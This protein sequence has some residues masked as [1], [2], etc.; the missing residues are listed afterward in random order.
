M[1]DEEVDSELLDLLN[2]TEVPAL[3]P[4]TP[5]PTITEPTPVAAP[6]SPSLAQALIVEPET[7]PHQAIPI[8]A[9]N[10][11]KPEDSLD[12]LGIKNLLEGFHSTSK[13]IIDNHAADRAQVDE[14]LKYLETQVKASV[15]AGDKAQTAMVDGWVK[16]L[17]TKAEINTNAVS[18]LDAQ[19]K[20][21]AAVKNNNVIVNV[22]GGSVGEGEIDL[23]TVF[24]QPLN[25]DEQIKSVL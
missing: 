3:P 21:L 4:T 17:Q 6:S 15:S 23:K 16:L 12:K 1:P 10:L 25:E 19:A 7:T 18:V 5:P 11:D 22:G 14:A 2:A 13:L 9:A 24:D 20:L 8:P